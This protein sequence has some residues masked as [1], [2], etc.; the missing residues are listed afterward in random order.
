MTEANEETQTKNQP[1]VPNPKT[2]QRRPRAKN[3]INPPTSKAKKKADP[4]LLLSPET[5]MKST[6]DQEL[7]FGTSSQLARDESP[8]DTRSK[9]Q[10]P[11]A[12]ELTDNQLTPKPTKETSMSSMPRFSGVG[13]SAITPF[14]SSKNLWSVATRN[15]DGALLNVEVVDLVDTPNPSKTA[16]APG[17]RAIPVPDKSSGGLDPSIEWKLIDEISE[18]NQLSNTSGKGTL[19]EQVDTPLEH[20]IP[21]SIAEASLRRRKSRS[22][23]KKPKA[24]TESEIPNPPNALNQMPNYTGFTTV[25]LAK[26]V[27]AYGFKAIKKRTE[28]IALL[29]RCWESQSRIALQVLPP[30][31]NLPESQP[32]M[33]NA[34]MPKQASPSKKTSRSRKASISAAKGDE[35]PAT[36]PSL[37]LKKPR[38]R[39]KKTSPAA[40]EIPTPALS[41]TIPRL[42]NSRPI[43]ITKTAP[44]PAPSLHALITL[45]VTTFPPT[46][47]ATDPSF[48][49]RIL[50]YEPIVLE[51]LTR[52]L[53]TVGLA[54]VGVDDEVSGALV[55]EWCEGRGVCCF[56]REE[57][58]R[59]KRG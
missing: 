57:G 36:D 24:P 22:P 19:I 53:N 21:R 46:H 58:W 39:P 42:T 25:D 1:A 9:R 38:G 12:S 14:A 29:E 2:V 32:S 31:T 27:A 44:A 41:P 20:S 10:S 15:M 49:E 34:D 4:P 30:P 40:P 23:V 35:N 6:E 16:P 33:I 51:D 3:K 52:W 56:W 7:I 47:S 59:A 50:L 17:Q 45:A 18:L 5:A 13:A 37:Q 28:M 43:N 26:A 48:Y 55:K 11:Q 54:R 8:I